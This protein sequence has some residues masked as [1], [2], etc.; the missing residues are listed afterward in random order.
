MRIVMLQ[1]VRRT[2][3]SLQSTRGSPYSGSGLGIA[4]KAL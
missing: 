3:Q 4:M 2:G 1:E